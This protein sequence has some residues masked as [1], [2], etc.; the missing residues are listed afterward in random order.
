MKTRGKV[1]LR[2]SE[3]SV[4][5][6][7]QTFPLQAPFL[8][9]SS[10]KNMEIKVIISL[11]FLIFLF[12]QL[13]NYKR[14]LHSQETKASRLVTLIF[15]TRLIYSLGKS[16]SPHTLPLDIFPSSFRHSKARLSQL[17]TDLTT[18]LRDIHVCMW[19]TRQRGGTREARRWAPATFDEARLPGSHSRATLFCRS[20][21][22]CELFNALLKPRQEPETRVPSSRPLSAPSPTCSETPARASS[23]FG[24]NFAYILFP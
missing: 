12:L 7:R 11:N 17:L 21:Q 18:V 23:N 13:T 14:L 19:R 8:N 6:G 10:K 22:T 1:I 3:A 16:V 4:W 2:K 9:F 20:R 15:S 5:N 24:P